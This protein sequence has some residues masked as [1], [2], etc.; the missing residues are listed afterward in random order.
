[1]A[2]RN[3][4]SGGGRTEAAISIRAESNPDGRYIPYSGGCLGWYE[5]MGVLKTERANNYLYHTVLDL[6]TVRRVLFAREGHDVNRRMDERIDVERE[7]HVTIVHGDNSHS[8][9]TKD[10]SANGLRLQLVEPTEMQKADSVIVQLKHDADSKPEVELRAQVMWVARVGKRRIV[11]NLGVGFTKITP[12]EQH[13]LKEFLLGA[14][15]A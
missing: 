12:K 6:Q 8:A 2:T 9:L 11:T 3:Q 1:M 7:V 5:N 15:A 4:R 14:G 13:T 10:V